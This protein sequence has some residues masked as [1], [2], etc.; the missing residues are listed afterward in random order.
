MQARSH[1]GSPTGRLGSHRRCRVLRRVLPVP[2]LA[3]ARQGDRHECAPAPRRP[4]SRSRH[5]QRAGAP[6]TALIPAL[7]FPSARRRGLPRPLEERPLPLALVVSS[8]RADRPPGARAIHPHARARLP[9]ASARLLRPCPNTLRGPSRTVHGAPRRST[10]SP[11]RRRG[12]SGS[13]SSGTASG[14]TCASRPCTGCVC[15][16]VRARFLSALK[17]GRDGAARLP[18]ALFP[19]WTLRRRRADDLS[20][21]APRAACRG[22]TRWPGWLGSSRTSPT[23]SSLPSSASAGGWRVSSAT[24]IPCSW[25]SPPLRAPALILR[26]GS[27]FPPATLVAGQCHSPRVLLLRPRPARWCAASQRTT[28]DAA[29][30]LLAIHSR[31]TPSSTPP[32][33]SPSPHPAPL[34]PALI[35]QGLRSLVLGA[36]LRSMGLEPAAV[37]ITVQGMRFSTVLN[38]ALMGRTGAHCLFPPPGPGRL[39]KGQQLTGSSAS[40]AEVLWRPRPVHRA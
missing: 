40:A 5:P 12:S 22:R 28:Q 13:S 38:Y 36:Y 25:L 37:D 18:T 15:A 7:A 14:R 24:R 17:R 33:F 10:T 6:R 30:L 1:L 35:P 39:C 29:H 31:S 9:C 16:C 11:P 8:R 20:R 21:P 26:M 32:P 34:R 19:N 4:R 3:P 23:T 27:A 2:P